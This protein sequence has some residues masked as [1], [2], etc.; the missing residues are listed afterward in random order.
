MKFLFIIL[1]LVFTYTSFAH[2]GHYHCEE[3]IEC[4]KKVSNCIQSR[5]QVY[6]LFYLVKKS[7]ICNDHGNEQDKIITIVRENYETGLDIN[8]CRFYGA[9]LKETYGVCPEDE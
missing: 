6:S 3:S 1:S 4:I 7:K 5:Y 2:Y 9:E 8:T